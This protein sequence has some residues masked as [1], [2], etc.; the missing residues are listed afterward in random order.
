[1]RFCT[2]HSSV[3]S[4]T[5]ERWTP[6]RGVTPV[7]STTPAATL[8]RTSQVRRRRRCWRLGRLGWR[9]RGPHARAGETWRTRA[10]RRRSRSGP[11]SVEARVQHESRNVDDSHDRK[12]SAAKKDRRRRRGWASARRSRFRRFFSVARLSWPGAWKLQTLRLLC[13]LKT[14]PV[15]PPSGGRAKH[16]CWQAVGQRPRWEFF[17]RFS[18]LALGAAAWPKVFFVVRLGDRDVLGASHWDALKKPPFVPW[19][20]GGEV[21][22][23]RLPLIR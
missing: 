10:G 5:L 20:T 15:S 16:G 21:G 22:A 11:G 2:E 18:V 12:I 14:S 4:A 9:T 1:M 17:A 13:S 8:R 19:T 6:S 3:K 7:G 23:C